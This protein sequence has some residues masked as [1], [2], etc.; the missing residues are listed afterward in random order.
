MFHPALTTS[1]SERMK[2]R[3]FSYFA[4]F[5]ARER[6]REAKPV[7]LKKV[8]FSH[9]F[10]TLRR[11]QQ[12]PH[13]F[14][15]PVPLVQ[16]LRR[17]GFRRPS[18]PAAPRRIPSEGARKKAAKPPK[19]H[20]RGGA[21]RPAGPF[22]RPRRGRNARGQRPAQRAASPSPGFAGAGSGRR[23]GEGAAGKRVPVKE[24]QRPADCSVR[25]R[26]IGFQKAGGGPHSGA[27][28]SCAGAA[29]PMRAARLASAAATA[30][31][32]SCSRATR[33]FWSISLASSGLSF[34]KLRA[35]S[36]P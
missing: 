28:P 4:G 31:A 29:P 26:C 27:G 19:R 33:S 18:G 10:D 2:T 17:S 13:L 34:R 14:M 8:A 1:A 23:P 22:P 6:M 36:R 21:A 16:R 5:A 30:S 35:F 12:R 25:R 9:F 3:R 20:P 15:Q 24:K 7:K 32:R 11:G